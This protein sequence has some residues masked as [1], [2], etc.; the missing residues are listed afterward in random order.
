MSEQRHAKLRKITAVKQGN[1]YLSKSKK[2]QIGKLKKQLK[3][4]HPH[5]YQQPSKQSKIQHPKNYP[6]DYASNDPIHELFFNEVS[7]LFTRKLC[8]RQTDILWCPTR[9][10]HCI[11]CFDWSGLRNN[12][13]Q[14]PSFLG[15][16]ISLEGRLRK[17]YRNEMYKGKLVPKCGPSS[18]VQAAHTTPH[19]N[20]FRRL[21]E[22]IEPM[23]DID[24]SV[25]EFI[26]L[27]NEKHK[28]GELNLVVK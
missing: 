6:G 19:V 9:C 22:V 16:N 11:Y 3:S 15:C 23:E 8:G 12:L 13:T 10:H 20:L 18:L 14:H 2:I 1:I 24:E 25:G 7:K 4:L 5:L 21:V 17:H 27:L 28:Y 26:S